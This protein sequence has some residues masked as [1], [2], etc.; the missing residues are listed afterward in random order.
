MKGTTGMKWLFFHYDTYLEFEQPVTEHQ[1]VLRCMPKTNDRQRVVGAEVKVSP[2]VPFVVQDDGFG[3]SIQT[4]CV[5]F[6]HN[7]FHYSTHGEVFVS[8]DNK[9]RAV[10]N[11]A[12]AYPSR[13]T[14]PTPEMLAFLKSLSLSGSTADRFA[15]A[16]R[17]SDAVH[18]HIS[19]RPDSTDVD[20]TA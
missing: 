9:D 15:D 18:R 3:N 16:G 19:Y 4:G 5:F 2:I 20:T 13:L 7:S 12:F 10:L 6:E 11:P 1:F 8:P 14:E 17:I